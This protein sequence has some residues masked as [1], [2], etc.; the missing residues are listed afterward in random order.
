MALDP[1]FQQG[2]NNWSKSIADRRQ[3]AQNLTK[4]TQAGQLKDL[5]ARQDSQAKSALERLKHQN[6]MP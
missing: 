5:L 2:M 1:F 6:L 4:L 3:Q